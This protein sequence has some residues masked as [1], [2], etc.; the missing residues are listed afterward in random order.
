MNLTINKILSKE[1]KWD[2]FISE[3]RWLSFDPSF[4]KEMVSYL[5]EDQCIQIAKKTKDGV[6]ANIRFI[7]GHSTIENTVDFIETWCKSANMSYRLTK[8]DQY[9]FIITHD[10]G[11][12]W[13]ILASE[14]TKEFIKELGFF[15]T[16]SIVEPK[17]YSF[18]ISEK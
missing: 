9:K 16:N 6:I 11:K 7:Y 3:M 13:S 17:N 10:I 18:V 5:T 8:N 2:D 12:N 15:F 4:V 14:V 1:V